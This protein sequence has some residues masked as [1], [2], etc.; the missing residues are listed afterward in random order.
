MAIGIGMHTE[1][2]DEYPE[3]KSLRDKIAPDHS[4]TSCSDA[5]PSN[6]SYSADDMGGCRRCDQIAAETVGLE[7]E[8]NRIRDKYVTLFTFY[9]LPRAATADEL[10]DA[11]GV[12]IRR[13]IRERRK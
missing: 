12:H 1:D 13:L 4:R 8:Q 6:G 9:E 2:E 11:M 7:N 5:H 3:D 10:I